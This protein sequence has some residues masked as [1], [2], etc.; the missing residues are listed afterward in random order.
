MTRSRGG[1]SEILRGVVHAGSGLF[2]LALRYLS[3][4]QAALVA[5]GAV[6]FNALVLP[7]LGARLFR[8]GERRLP[9]DSG[10]HL[11]PFAVLILVLVFGWRM[12][13]AAA[14]WVI[15]AAGDPAARAAG[16]TIGGRRLP[17][18]G[19]KSVAGTS[20]FAAAAFAATFGILVYMGRESWEA[21]ILAAPTALF[22]AFV[23]SLPWRLN[24]NLTVPIL[25][26]L[27]LCGLVA[28]EAT[29]LPEILPALG[30]PLAVAIAV[31]AALAVVFRWTG[32]VDRSGMAAGFLVGTL[33]W[34]FGG[35]PAFAILIAF[36]VLGSAATRLGRARKE[37]LGVAQGKKGARSARHAIANCGVAVYLAILAAVA[38][39]PALYLVAFVAA[40]ATAAFDTLSSE[41]GQAWGGRPVMI[42]TLRRVAVGTDG[43]VSLLGTLAGF[44]G[45][46]VVALLARASGL[47]APAAIPI[48]L[49]AA[50]IGS[51]ADS[52]LGATLERRG[53]MDNEAVNFSNTLIGALAAVAGALLA[54]AADGAPG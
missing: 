22:A 48:V 21:A 24:D 52:L 47:I 23:E 34:T 53:L 50:F 30:R 10:I 40:Y 28:A 35:A 49:V 46:L 29:R 33:T 7:R 41:I 54:S 39:A 1:T 14:G 11:Y 18:N 51:S 31:N 9:L 4:P 44:G 32:T 12:E 25:S 5:A 15:M 20:A 3:V 45:A 13:V 26:A 2:A 16:M 43:A 27:F 36:F 6:V 17:W 38:P 8:D 42:T 37:R 19:S